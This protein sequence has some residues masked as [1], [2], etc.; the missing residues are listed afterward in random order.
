M[1]RVAEASWVP[2]AALFS[3]KFIESLSEG[4]GRRSAGRMSQ[5][6]MVSQGCQSEYLQPPSDCV[7]ALALHLTLELASPQIFQKCL[8]GKIQ[9][10]K[11]KN[12]G[13]Y[14]EKLTN[15]EF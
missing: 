3:P 8:C 5:S 11:T 7:P 4:E 1:P 12:K 14:T 10:D 9:L 15:S 6:S 13:R 2:C